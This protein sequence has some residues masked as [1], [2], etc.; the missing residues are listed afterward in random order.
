M[1]RASSLPAA[2]L[3]LAGV[4][5]APQ[6]HAGGPRFI[7]GTNL[8]GIGP[9]V[10]MPF[11]T[12]Q[13][14]YY[15]D[16]GN[17]ASNVTH[18]Q[19]D[20]LVAA[21]AAVWNVPYT[22]LTLAQGGELAE[23]IS[24]SNA[25][26]NGT[27]MIFPADASASNYLNIPIAIVYDTDGSVTDQLLGAGASSPAGCRQNG[28]TSTD[29]S[30][31]QT[32]QIL[33]AVIILNGRCVGSA[34]Q[35]ITQMQYQ[36]M[37]AFGRVLGLAWAQL[38][39]NVFTG[40]P[41][42]T[43]SDMAY[44]PVMHPIDVLCSSYTYQCMQNPF[45][46]RMDDISAL[47][48]LYPQ[49]TTNSATGKIATLDGSDIMGGLV[50]FPTG[51]GMEMVNITVKRW[52][53]GAAV[54]ET[55][56][57]VSGVSGY[58]FQA[59]G[60]NRVSGGESSAANSGRGDT[61]AEGYY[62][63]GR[64][65]TNLGTDLFLVAEPVNPLYTGAYALGNFQRPVPTMSGPPGLAY[66]W[67]VWPGY[68]FTL[69]IAQASTATT[70]NP[71]A[72]G[73]EIAPAASDPTG[74][75]LRQLCGI[76]HQS[77]FGVTIQP[78]RT[79]TLETK[80]LDESGLA[81][82]YKAQPVLGVWNSSDPV[83]GS[84]PTVA[85]AT[86][87]MNAMAPGVTQLHM[88]SSTSAASYRVVV[89]D[90]FGGGRPDFG[91]QARVLYAASITPAV[92]GI[93]GGLITITGTGFLTGN[94]VLVNGVA[95]TVTATTATQIQAIAPS[96]SSIGA[97]Q[98]SPVSVEVYDA[99]TGGST[100]IS[101]ALSYSN[102]PDLIQTVSAPSALYTAIASTTPFTVQT[103][104]AG[105]SAPA[106]GATVTVS[107]T[108]GSALLGCGS[109]TCSYTT[110]ASGHASTVITGQIP[111]NVTITAT[112]LSG[113]NSV[114]LSLL[115]TTPTLALTIAQPSAY[116]AAG[117][118]ASWTIATAATLNGGPGISAPMTWS[119]S[120][121]ARL[122]AGSALA[123]TL[124]DASA[125]FS[126]TSAA[127]G[128]YSLQAC[129]WNL[130]CSSWSVTAIDSSLWVPAVTSGAG[131]S[132]PQT[133]TL[134]P[135]IVTITDGSGHALPG[136]T[137]TI[138]QQVNAWEGP[139]PATGVCPAA[140]LLGKSG[141]TAIADASGNVQITPLEV[142]GQPEVVHIAVI[143][144]AQGFLSLSLVKT[145]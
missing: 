62:Q 100:T 39:D 127:T 76:G 92:V 123:D 139:C 50:S 131:Q 30:F 29:D 78:G 135:V 15:T 95:A 66:G 53:A 142:T 86:F 59:T 111:G 80:A 90:Q 32:G 126:L 5:L 130:V 134:A 143:T 2:A 69:N 113:G 12:P 128:T 138:N 110:D 18:A 112:E 63:L 54:E 21:A 144:G 77:W 70:C 56:Q 9:G 44:W 104:T 120:S 122:S 14:N 40:S 19:A 118:S 11:Y 81:T 36:V 109:A 108:Q 64:V 119:A 74:L 49:A 41:A 58:L 116:L 79:W 47:S 107:V 101:A 99:G 51:T 38:D 117:A 103:L 145:P 31:S 27:Q 94:R 132:V 24:S 45:A 115:D 133:A 89:E 17:L 125:V 71:G 136:A 106:V 65:V 73:T 67:S 25:Y 85:S 28:V 8:S 33:H 61:Y 52:L 68:G 72:D 16:S 23:H 43:A 82:L 114:T 88:P 75:W 1:L 93:G 96:L 97:A 60:G 124:G 84:L 35:Q 3:L 121:G 22:S 48:E 7:T 141:T 20:A 26:F 10:P 98:G 83:N 129:A 37:R 140:P 4:L 13:L 34:P 105:G 46:L 137:V 102:A 6:A 87:A 55:S 57:A 42:P 91:Y